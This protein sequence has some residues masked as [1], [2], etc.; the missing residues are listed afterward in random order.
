[1]S[2]FLLGYVVGLLVL[3]GVT[4]YDHKVFQRR[5]M[6]RMLRNLGRQLEEMAEQMAAA[7]KLK[8]IEEPP[9]PGVR[10]AGA[11]L[12][13]TAEAL[14]SGKPELLAYSTSE[15]EMTMEVGPEGRGE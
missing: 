1:M 11:M 6:V 5:R 3:F 9:A 8:E 12:M 2:Y 15:W 4:V 14:E 7:A 13:V 10:L